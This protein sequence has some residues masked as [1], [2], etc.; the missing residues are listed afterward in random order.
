MSGNQTSVEEHKFNPETRGWAGVWDAVDYRRARA[1]IG[2]WFYRGDLQA[3]EDELLEHERVLA[4]RPDG[5]GGAIAVTTHRL[6]VTGK[7][8]QVFLCG[9][10]ALPPEFVDALRAQAADPPSP[11]GA[12]DQGAQP[13]R[14]RRLKPGRS[15]SRPHSRPALGLRVRPAP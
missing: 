12:V 4:V 9:R 15:R 13:C 7:E 14:G 6:L 1:R 11:H 3:I 8:V 5:N 2:F 10:S